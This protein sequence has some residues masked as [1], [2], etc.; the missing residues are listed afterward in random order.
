MTQKLKLTI[1]IEYDAEPRDYE[2]SNDADEM[3][4]MDYNQFHELLDFNG[5]DIFGLSQFLRD[6]FGTEKFT[7]TVSPA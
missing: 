6:Y 7:L 1:N 2:Y 3:A 4:D 5:T